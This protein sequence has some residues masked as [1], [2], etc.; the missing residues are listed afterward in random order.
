MAKFWG[1]CNGA[2]F[3][4]DECFRREKV[5]KRWVPEV[6]GHFVWVEVCPK[7]ILHA[8]AGRSNVGI[9]H[10]HNMPSAGT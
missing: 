8:V 6:D 7:Q 5:I 1:V 9:S 4:L 10:V 2:K 3:A